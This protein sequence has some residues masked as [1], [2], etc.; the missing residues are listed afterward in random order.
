[1]IFRYLFAC[2]SCEHPA[3]PRSFPLCQDCL[4]KP[5]S[6]PLL[7]DL[8]GSH[9]CV[10]R[11]EECFGTQDQAI[12]RS[13]TARYLLI[14]PGYTVLKSWKKH[15]GPLFDRKILRADTA[16]LSAL[17]RRIGNP[18]LTALV[19]LPQSFDRTWQLGR[20]PALSVAQWLSSETGVELKADLLT[21]KNLLSRKLRQ[22][23]LGLESRLQT[24]SQVMAT[25]QA[26]ILAQSRKI[27]SILLVDDFMTSGH[28]LRN[29]ALALKEAGFPDIHAVVL[30]Y[31]PRQ[32][33]GDG[34]SASPPALSE[35]SAPSDS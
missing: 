6:A 18:A 13:Y 2:R 34:V 33:V 25:E 16:F 10:F 15:G 27:R 24:P 35:L 3:S 28:T 26:T 14:E 7:C 29:A 5:L 20:S 30:G 4:A 8:C 12:I 19:P 31:R 22:A 17:R 32:F 23:Q 1:M 21:L 9:L 11:P